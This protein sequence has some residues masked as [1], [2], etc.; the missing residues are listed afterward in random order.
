MKKLLS[1]LFVLFI[2]SFSQA[3]WIVE[4]FD[5][6]V[7]PVFP[8][9]P[10]RGST[11]FANDAALTAEFNLANDLDHIQGTGSMKIDYRI[12]ATDSWGG[13]VVRTSTAGT[14]P[15][16]PPY[17]DL[18]TGTQL[19]IKYKVLTVADTSKGGTVF[20]ELKLAEYDEAATG[21]DLWRH[22]TSINLFDN[23]G[24]WQEAIIP[25]VFN[26]DENLGFDLQF[27]DGDQKIQWDKIKGFELALVYLTA[28]NAAT[29]PT[30][31][32]SLLIDKLELVGNRYSPVLTFDNSASSYGL[33]WMDWAGADKGA[34]AVTDE[35]TDLVEGTGSLKVDYTLSAPFG[36][37]GFVALDTAV[38][39]DSTMEERTALTLFVK[40]LVPVV[41]DSGRAFMR[42]FIME[43]S[44]GANEE[45][46]TDIGIDLSEASDWNRYYLPLVAKPMGVNDR[47]PPKDGFALKNGAGDLIFN[48]AKMT[49]IRIEIFGRGTEDGFAGTLKSDGSLL[50]D[51]MQQSGFQFADKTAPAPPVVTLI[52]DAFSNL[53]TWLDVPGET[54]EKYFVYYSTNPITDLTADGVEFLIDPIAEGNGVY[55][56]NIYSANTDKDKTYY[57]AVTAKDF[58][59]NVSLP[60]F[61]APITNTAKGIPTVSITPPS[62]FVADGNLNEWTSA[63]PS[64]V[65]SAALGTANVPPPPQVVN[66][67]AD[68][69]AEVKVALDDTYL[70]VMMDVTDDAVFWVDDVSTWQND[71]ADIYIGFYNVTTTHRPYWRGDKPDYHIRFGKFKIRNDGGGAETDSVIANGSENY[72]WGEKFPSGYIIEARIPLIDLATMRDNIS[73]T[74]DV[75]TWKVGDRIPFDIGIN[76]NDGNEVDADHPGVDREGMIFYSP[77]NRDNGYRYVDSWTQTWISDEVT[78]V[79]DNP[80]AVNTFSLAQNYPNPFNPSTQI[81]YSIAEAG[82]V[83]IKVYDILGREVVNLVNSQQAAGTYS[84]DFNA[85]SLSTGVY[86]YRIESGSFQDTKKMVLLK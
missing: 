31:T 70:Y 59:G 83:S 84:V 75:I 64:F 74:T 36:W 44:A 40:N 69:S 23:S 52:P 63:Q 15:N 7:G 82:L 22:H 16:T 81:Q 58:A 48:P 8:D 24:A 72:F 54:G 34:L 2:A 55:V 51:I 45:W 17:I 61:S 66:G 50:L 79:D 43:N 28:G 29:P 67:D 60:G 37:G 11:F 57:Y 73:Q 5:N 9:P 18:S 3:Q 68:C 76:D 41:A 20:M 53:V 21:R 77:T 85:Q 56:H 49:K 47:F 26:D 19:K 38:T 46:I 30:A 80:A 78:G 27:G 25:L 35:G 14:V 13:F 1:L 32:G 33:D 10:V 86:I 62:S 71:A 39:V 4:S 42:V 12:E 65:M 6:A